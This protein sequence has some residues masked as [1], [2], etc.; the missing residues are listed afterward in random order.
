[1]LDVNVSLVVLTTDIENKKQY[2]LSTEK[3]KIKFIRLKVDQNNKKDIEK[4]ICEYVR[5][6]YLFLSDYEILPQFVSFNANNLCENDDS[7]EIVYG[8]VIPLETQINEETC[9]WMPFE[10]LD[11]DKVDSKLVKKKDKNLFSSP[12]D[13]ATGFINIQD[14]NLSNIEKQIRD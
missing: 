8:S 5:H 9:Y 13:T 12:K 2:V 1:M 10:I 6:N 14:I 11:D 7:L 3:N 4:A